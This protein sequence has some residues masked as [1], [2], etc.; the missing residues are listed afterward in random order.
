MKY[1]VQAGKQLPPILRRFDD[2]IDLEFKKIVHSLALTYKIVPG[3]K[4][5]GRDNERKEE[6]TS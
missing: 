5:G 1:F 2:G 3:F 6:L 4:K